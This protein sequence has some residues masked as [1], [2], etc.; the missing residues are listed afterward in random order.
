LFI[1]FPRGTL[2]GTRE[3]KEGASSL[4]TFL[5]GFH[6]EK[7]GIGKTLFGE[8]QRRKWLDEFL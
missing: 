1:S 8:I 7:E 6:G 3:G 4:Y 5:H 2:K